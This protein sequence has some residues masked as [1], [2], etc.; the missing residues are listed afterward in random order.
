MSLFELLLLGL[1]AG[2]LAGLMMKSGGFGLIGNLAIGVVGVL[3]CGYLFRL[4][5]IQAYGLYSA[6]VTVTVGAMLVLFVAGL[7]KRG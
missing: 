5:G 4:I 3:L 2:W 6:L 7:N 1:F